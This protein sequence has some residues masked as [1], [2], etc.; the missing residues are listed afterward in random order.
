[1]TDLSSKYFIG[2]HEGSWFLGEWLSTMHRASP[3]IL[4]ETF[5]VQIPNPL[6]ARFRAF[7]SKPLDSIKDPNAD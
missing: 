7:L 4:S 3:T 2:F 6:S 5:I 1:M